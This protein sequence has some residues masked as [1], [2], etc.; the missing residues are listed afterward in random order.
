MWIKC[1]PSGC[2]MEKAPISGAPLRRAN[3]AAAGVGD[4]GDEA[5]A[6]SNPALQDFPAFGPDVCQVFVAEA[7]H[8]L[9]E[10]PPE[11]QVARAADLLPLRIGEVGKG[12][13]QPIEGHGTAQAEEPGQR[14]EPLAQPQQRRPHRTASSALSRASAPLRMRTSMRTA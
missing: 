4:G 6:L 3:T 13:A 14:S 1:L 10:A 12:A 2:R 5:P 8:D 7:Q 9:G 11:L